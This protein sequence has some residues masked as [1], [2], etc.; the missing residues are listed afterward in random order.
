MNQYNIIHQYINSAFDQHVYKYYVS[1]RLTHT[2]N[3]IL[4]ETARNASMKIYPIYEMSDSEI[5]NPLKHIN[6]YAYIISL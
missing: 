4:W 1:N 3:N 2:L 5:L 6:F